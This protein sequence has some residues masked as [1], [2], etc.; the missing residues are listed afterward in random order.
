[1]SSLDSSTVNHFSRRSGKGCCAKGNW[2]GMNIAAMV[3]GF[4]LFWPVGLVV[5]YWNIS[6][7]DVRDL[8]S[9]VQEKW[10]TLFNTKRHKGSNSEN[11][12]FDE[13]QQTQYDRISE[14]K[15]EIVARA[16]SF[17]DFRSDAKR[18]K[19]EVE[20]KDFMSSSPKQK[21]K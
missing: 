11:S 8:P 18:R 3:I 9:T 1:M 13:F 4:L 12:I 6:G 17:R 20:F 21:D 5:L 10:S 19:D 7:R 2:S 16:R 15:E 14:I